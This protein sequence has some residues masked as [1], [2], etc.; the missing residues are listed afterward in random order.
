MLI[1]NS[2]IL[3]SFKNRKVPLCMYWAENIDLAYN[4][5]Y[6]FYTD[7]TIKV[8]F[9]DVSSIDYV[10]STSSKQSITEKSYCIWEWHF[11]PWESWKEPQTITI[12][13]RFVSYVG[14]WDSDPDLSCFIP[15]E[16]R[17]LWY[18]TLYK[19]VRLTADF[20][21][22]S[23]GL[24]VIPGTLYVDSLPVWVFIP[25]HCPDS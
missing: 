6:N 18:Q 8:D 2:Y 23:W 17:M 22:L 24:T 12:P 3:M 16:I 25:F 20:W 9:L 5:F 7:I 14:T 21:S 19:K 15:H 13:W 10:S 1:Y 11:S 4:Y